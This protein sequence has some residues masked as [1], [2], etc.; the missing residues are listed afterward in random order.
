MGEAQ[1]EGVCSRGWPP[2]GVRA[3]GDKDP[4][5]TGGPGAARMCG[6]SA[7]RGSVGLADPAESVAG[8]SGRVS[9][10]AWGVLPGTRA[11]VREG[12]LRSEVGEETE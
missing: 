3:E 9:A 8:H 6:W 12:E 2:T 5:R 11:R 10:E 7:G 1:D 4:R